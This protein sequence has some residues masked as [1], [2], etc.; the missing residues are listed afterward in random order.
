MQLGS[1]NPMIVLPVVCDGLTDRPDAIAAVRLRT[2]K[3]I[4]F[5]EQWGSAAPGD[6][7]LRRR[8]LEPWWRRGW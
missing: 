4:E 2:I 7:D 1:A 5:A 8:R 6:D 3:R